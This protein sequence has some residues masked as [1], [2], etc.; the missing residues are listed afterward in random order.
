MLTGQDQ[1][2]YVGVLDLEKLSRPR[3]PCKSCNRM[4]AIC[5][6]LIPYLCVELPWTINLK[7]L[8]FA[9]CT[10]NN[11]SGGSE[12]SQQLKGSY[13]CPK[14][15]TIK[16]QT[17][18]TKPF[19][20]LG[21]QCNSSIRVNSG[22]SAWIKG[23]TCGLR[24]WRTSNSNS[25]SLSLLRFLPSLGPFVHREAVLWFDPL[26]SRKFCCMPSTHTIKTYQNHHW[27]LQNLCP[28]C[29]RHILHWQAGRA[30]NFSNS[31]S[32]YVLAVAVSRGHSCEK[33]RI[34]IQWL[35]LWSPSPTYAKSWES[36]K[37]SRGRANSLRK[38]KQ[39]PATAWWAAEH[40]SESFPFSVQT[41]TKCTACH[42]RI[43]C[44]CTLGI[45]ME[46]LPSVSPRQF[47][48]HRFI[49]AQRMQ[50]SL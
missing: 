31:F 35:W 23:K 4:V 47:A 20:T 24:S 13:I 33:Q 21:A 2:I 28:S 45:S 38:E 7:N 16:H 3:R 50:I 10:S 37:N 8:D 30:V 9:T 32:C 34:N 25:L 1:Q 36:R 18:R 5:H 19:G 40:C 22:S 42:C 27:Q 29:L 17:G 44:R 41:V 15:S 48:D 49:A 46:S 26:G 11:W 43:A 6:R 12:W 14:L 39:F